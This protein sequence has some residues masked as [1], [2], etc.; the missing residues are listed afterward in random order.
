LV[1]LYIDDPHVN[2]VEER[3]K[4]NYEKIKE[5]IDVQRGYTTREGV[6]LREILSYTSFS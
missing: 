2:R 5:K 6:N 4:G 1:Y 3:E